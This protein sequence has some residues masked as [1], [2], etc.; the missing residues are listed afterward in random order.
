[1]PPAVLA[2]TLRRG[3]A[4]PPPA[5]AAGLTRDWHVD[6]DN[7]RAEYPSTGEVIDTAT[8]R[9]VAALTDETGRPVHSGKVVEIHF[10]GGVPVAAGEQ[11]GLG[12][13][14]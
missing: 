12:R 10:R 1:M 7:F 3:E 2:D 11:F 13:R 5:T 9:V 4:G 14:P 8:R 6:W